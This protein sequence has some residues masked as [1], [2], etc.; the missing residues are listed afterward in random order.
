MLT[1]PLPLVSF[2]VPLYGG[3]STTVSL[4]FFYL[5]WISLIWRSKDPMTIEIYGTLIIRLFCY[6]IPSLLSLC[7]DSVIPSMSRKVKASGK[8]H[9][10]HQLGR[11]RLLRIAA[12]ATG[13]V[14]LGVLIQALPEVVATRILHLRSLLRLSTTVPLPWTLLKNVIQGL[15][16]RGIV[17]YALHRYVLHEWQSVLRKWHLQYQHCTEITF[18]LLAAYEHPV[19][20]L[21]VAFMPTFLPA[22]IF[23]WHGLTWHLFLILISLEE[24][25]VF[26]GYTV[27]PLTIISGGMAR[28][29]EAHFASVGDDYG[30]GNYG[31]LGVLEFCFGTA[32]PDED[33]VI[34]DIQDE[35]EKHNVQDRV[36]NAV[37]AGMSKLKKQKVRKRR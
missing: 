9:L 6:L 16:L 33:D 3:S 7:F 26:S 23:R 13:N 21:L 31:R 22:V 5:T 18:G 19:T 29:N 34:D 8:R 28:R 14:F 37:D 25:V 1:L 12:L 30:I 35:A 10:P 2:I 20:Y 24:F 27:L 32:C 36:T 4:G 15:A 11:D 17:H